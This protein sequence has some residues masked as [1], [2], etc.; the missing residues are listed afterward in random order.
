M[1]RKLLSLPSFFVLLLI[2]GIAFL[3]VPVA[4]LHAVP[5]LAATGAITRAGVP[6]G[7]KSGADN[8]ATNAVDT[9]GTRNLAIIKFQ[10]AVK[11]T[12]EAA[13]KFDADDVKVVITNISAN[14]ALPFEE[15]LRSTKVTVTPIGTTAVAAS[16]TV[17]PLPAASIANSWF[18]VSAAVPENGTGEI[19]VFVRGTDDGGAFQDAGDNSVWATAANQPATGTA[20]VVN[21]NTYNPVPVI[22][23]TA[24]ASAGLAPFTVT[25]TIYDNDPI[26][27][28]PTFTSA[29]IDIVGGTVGDVG[30]VTPIDPAVAGTGDLTGLS[31]RYMVSAYIEAP[32]TS[33]SVVIG[34][35]ADVVT[36]AGGS[37]NAAIPTTKTGTPP[38]LA[39]G[40]VEVTVDQ[41]RPEVMITGEDGA[42]LTTATVSVPFTVEF[43][44]QKTV[45]TGTPP[46]TTQ[47]TTVYNRDDLLATNNAL[48]DPL[49]VPTTGDK[50]VTV[51]GGTL[52]GFGPKAGSFKAWTAMV[53]P[54][55]TAEEVV[56]TVGAGTVKGPS[57][58]GNEVEIA[59]VTTDY[60]APPI[61]P[62]PST[63]PNAIGDPLPTG[64]VGF[65]FA[66]PS[67]PANGFVVLAKNP[68]SAGFTTA[69][70]A[71]D[72]FDT[73]KVG[74]A[75]VA[76]AVWQDLK[77]FLVTRE[78]GTIDLIG[79]TGSAVKSLVISEVMWGNDAGLGVGSETNS[80]WIELYNTTNAPIS[81]GTWT[82]EFTAKSRGGAMP[83]GDAAKV[84]T[85]AP[86]GGVTTSNAPVVDKLSTWRDVGS[87][88]D[89][90]ITDSAG[91]S[92]GQS[93]KSTPNSATSIGNQVELVSMQR[94]INYDN[95]VK[96]HNNSDAVKNRTEQ[97]K[98]VPG[99][100]AA[101]NWEA[102]PEHGEMLTWRKGTP[103]AA[104]T[105]KKVDQSGI[106]RGSVVFNEIANR[107]DKKHDW[108]ELYNKS[109]SAKKINDW[110]LSVVSVDSDGNRDDR[111]LFV[112]T[113]DE[114]IN[115][116]AGGYLLIVNQDPRK[117]T[118]EG[119]FDVVTPGN[120][121][122]QSNG[123][124][125]K[126][127]RLYYVSDK[128]DIPDKDF[129]LILRHGKD[130]RAT[131]EKVE[132][133]AGHNPRFDDN[134]KS[135]Q[136]WPLNSWSVGALDDLGQK[137]DK[138]WLR[139]QG[140][141][142]FHGDAWKPDGGFTGLGIDRD[143][144]TG[145]YT[146]GTPGYANNA[147][148]TEVK[149]DGLT[150]AN[151]VIISEIMFGSNG[152]APQWIELHNPSHTQAVNLKG[153]ELE[154]F[155]YYGDDTLEVKRNAE[156]K[157]LPEVR[158]QP[159]Q[160]I[161]I[162]SRATGRTSDSKAFPDNRIIDVWAN[163]ELRR[164]LDMDSQRDAILSATGFYLR[165][166]DPR[167]TLVDEVGNIDSGRTAEPDWTLPG[168]KLDD[169]S[170]R[171]SM[172]RD[173]EGSAG[174]GTEKDAWRDASMVDSS[175][176]QP[177]AY[178]LY[179]GDDDDIGTP[180]YTPGGVLPV[181]LSSFYSKRNDTG[182]V[183][184]TWSTESELDNAG[185][186]ILRSQSRTGEFVRIN[187]QLIPGAGTTGEKTAYTWT[188]TGASPNVLYFYQ[189][190]DVSLAGDHRTLRT[191]RLRGYIGAAGKATTTWGDLKSRE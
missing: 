65:T 118:L 84:T 170:G 111:E 185:F 119:G 42:A 12:G 180:G 60:T 145:D 82:L 149:S 78:G 109:G 125:N 46:T 48:A 68:A 94:K 102:T 162:V 9:S 139:D 62:D 161:L 53:T 58:N 153:W 182:A 7:A 169:G 120:S 88:W 95:V 105:I 67:V 26:A 40:A 113:S 131:H 71:I 163:T 138:T 130:K 61:T 123:A 128:L 20:H 87:Y 156:L 10:A 134:A 50:D 133:V 143:A 168:G 23:I 184:I 187:A 28:A 176:I 97:L 191:T 43:T 81:A 41:V 107:S 144:G 155:N 14:T 83:T 72:I 85:A 18:V 13:E 173:L 91:G 56:I 167:G 27:T 142:V 39:A 51:T 8:T 183:V 146:S 64:R 152:G 147:V 140:K 4:E 30:P 148:Q 135:T 22:A 24:P 54:N 21:Y 164:A 137:N 157:P 44:V 70:S 101:D 17:A 154:I 1:E 37:K 127:S 32:S 92:H 150:N 79:P 49:E 73:K 76:V 3:A 29:S 45:T 141:A 103:G 174:D 178:E 188:D 93:G 89:W 121:T 122:R 35:K 90:R 11:I 5:E 66:L 112:F 106:A 175:K 52:S 31:S 59:R 100:V 181:Q 16:A 38:A 172:V 86:L 151:P 177:D 99:G 159:N 69:V 124:G 80:Q 115:V 36:D 57:G 33:Q 166:S 158:I 179:Y 189:I 132:D 47:T 186:N 63:E 2:A 126:P 104:P 116:P 77:H 34:V 25:F 117:T 129:L 110:M 19:R 165:L 75:D 136:V 15:T 98:A 74:N 96:T 55:A 190:E 6:T 108:I 114:D 171:S 160:T